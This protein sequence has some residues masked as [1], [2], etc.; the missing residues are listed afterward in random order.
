MKKL[1]YSA[2]G[3]AL[4][5][6]SN[7]VYALDCA[8]Q[9]PQGPQAILE[10]I[11]GNHGQT[12][13]IYW[14]NIL[15]SSSM[16][17]D[18]FCQTSLPSDATQAQKEMY[19]VGCSV[20]KG[21]YFSYANFIAADQAMRTKFGSNYTFLRSSDYTINLKEFANFL[22]TLAQ[23]T[24][25]MIPGMKNQN[26]G[27]YFRYENG[28]LGPNACYDYSANPTDRAGTQG[29]NCANL[30]LSSYKTGYYPK[31]SYVVAVDSTTPSNVY[32]GY[33]F[34]G[35][36]EYMLNTSPISIMFPGIPEII[37]SLPQY[38]DVATKLLNPLVVASW[39]NTLSGFQWQFMNQT[40]D[41]GYWIGMGNL[42][43]TGDS[44]TKFFG[45]YS[46]SFA[47]TPVVTS[48]NLQDFVKQYLQDGVLAWEG[49]LWYWMYRVNG[50]GLPTLHSIISDSPKAACHD[51][52]ISTMMVNGGCNNYINE[53]GT[54]RKAYYQFFLAK[55]GMTMTAV[56]Y[57][58]YGQTYNSLQC[59]D[60][61]YEYC[62]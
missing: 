17:L 39:G 5:G 43:L 28:A 2:L 9:N 57:E 40:I 3:F 13:E 59:N 48:R 54:G 38:K 34:D 31:S 60:Q 25:G 11:A 53:D 15:F 21:S 49:G 62:K 4:L 10:C 19:V 58:L 51:I 32:T 27:L 50:Y 45:W 18:K 37:A 24:T 7:L 29:R 47:N 46:Q 61:I 44:M 33:V 16:A 56:P 42:Q 55:F 14:N 36:G 26:D 20:Q 30:G 12:A 52:A 22:A 23:E 8:S 1:T 35:D 6:A 41:P